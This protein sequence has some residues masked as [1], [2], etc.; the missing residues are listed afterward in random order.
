MHRLENNLRH[1]DPYGQY[2]QWFEEKV[3]NN[4]RTLSFF[5]R[6]ILDCIRYLLCQIAYQ[7]DLLY[8]PCHGYDQHGQRMFSEM[9]TANWWWDVQVNS[10]ILFEVKRS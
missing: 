5:Y 4:Q 8:A 6:N 2:L 1:L 10:P 7:D 3:E 9:H